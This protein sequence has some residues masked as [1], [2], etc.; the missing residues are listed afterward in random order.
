VLARVLTAGSE[1][2]SCEE[3]GAVAILS[4]SHEIRAE[5]D[6]VLR[7]AHFTTSD[8]NRRFL[9]Y[10]VE[11]TLAG[12]AERLKA[13]TIATVV[14]GR[15][16]SFD[17]QMDPVVRMEA[18]RLRRALERLYLIDGDMGSVQ[19]TIPKG[20]YVPEFTGVGSLTQLRP[21]P[22]TIVAGET[23]P[24]VVTLFEAQGDP[25]TPLSLNVGFTRQV[26][27]DLHRRGCWVVFGSQVNLS[28]AFEAA[29]GA[30]SGKRACVVTGDVGLVDQVLSVT[31]LLIDTST[32]RVL[33]GSTLRRDVPPGENA[34]S[35]RD[36]VAAS[37]AET[38]HERL[39]GL[40]GQ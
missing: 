15:P 36:E 33:W 17:P 11:E 9:Q 27:V 14:F 22:R 40:P 2:I 21:A 3:A 4:A 39:R 5:L 26:M 35:V 6:R 23:V 7:S 19:I 8:R 37:V 28:A 18:G 25:S 24:V 32:G 16:D 10:V 38:I 20:R 13:Y 34:L 30:T 1:R 31:A 29:N 12:R